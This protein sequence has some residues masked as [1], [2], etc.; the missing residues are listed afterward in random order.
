[1]LVRTPILSR[2]FTL[3]VVVALV[4]LS[5]ILGLEISVAVARPPLET[6]EFT[7]QSSAASVDRTRKGDLMSLAAVRS[8]RK[9]QRPELRPPAAGS[10]L[11]AGCEASVSSLAR[12][13]WSAV[14]ARCVS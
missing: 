11:A 6:L 7:R 4:V 8:N 12:T 2:S 10:K 9:M 1:M 3:S 5:V 14:A 13:E